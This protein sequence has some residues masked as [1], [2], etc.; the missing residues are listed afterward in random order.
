MNSLRLSVINTLVRQDIFYALRSTRGSLFLVFFGIFWLWV[1]WK[2]SSGNAQYLAN[3]EASFILSIIIDSKVAQ[4]LFVDR[5]PTFSAFFYL[6]ISTVPMF[7]LFAASDQTANDIGSKYLRFL[8]P[9]CNRLEIYIARFFGAFVLIAVSYLII[10]LIAALISIMVDK[11]ALTLVLRDFPLVVISVILYA[12]P[13][14]A[15]MSL[16]SVIV[17]SAG[18]SALLGFSIY[19]ILLVI[20]AVIGIKMSGVADVLGY[21]LPNATKTT[22]LQLSWSGM[23]TVALSVPVYVGIYGYL[24]W[25]MFSKRDI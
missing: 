23:V 14:I 9:R 4:S 8:T 20:T 16:C 13:F 2:L 24:G 6:A 7:I 15:F 17:G 21:V 12:I 25:I 5:S 1:L 22:V 18:L 19:T 11:D 10:C 3:P